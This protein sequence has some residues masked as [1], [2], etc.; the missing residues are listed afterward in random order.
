M[1]SDST[2]FE[3]TDFETTEEFAARLRLHPETVRR[4]I[5]S[6]RLHG[7]RVGR[8]WRISSKEIERI[9]AEGV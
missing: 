8:H 3:T 4:W 5:R 6:R 2:H 7:V 9:E 1:R